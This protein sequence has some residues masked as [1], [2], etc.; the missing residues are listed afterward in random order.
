MDGMETY[1]N[2]SVLASTNRPELLDDALLRPGRF[3]YK[4][5][6]KKPTTIGC[7]KIFEILTKDMPIANTVDI[8]KITNKLQGLSGAEI[9]FIINEAAYNCMRRSMDLKNIIKL[10]FDEQIDIDKLF[11]TENDFIAAFSKIK[12]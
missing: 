5:E 7:K 9:A 3:D 6:I 1:G 2:V 12:E 8:D 10:Q 11:I 4:I